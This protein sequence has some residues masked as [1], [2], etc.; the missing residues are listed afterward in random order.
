[1]NI[2]DSR[3]QCQTIDDSMVKAIPTNRS[4]IYYK[5]T[6]YISR[7][8][9]LSLFLPSFLL[10]LE[11]IECNN[12]FSNTHSLLSHSHSLYGFLPGKRSKGDCQI[13]S[14]AFNTSIPALQ[15][16]RR[17]EGTYKRGGGIC[18]SVERHTSLKT[19]MAPLCVCVCHRLSPTPSSTLVVGACRPRKP[20]ATCRGRQRGS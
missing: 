17:S 13:C 4:S 15:R 6:K 12:T 16:R 8:L 7:S 5:Q 20:K 10:S 19:Q 2:R 11:L 18:E 14:S 9:S 3:K 1:M